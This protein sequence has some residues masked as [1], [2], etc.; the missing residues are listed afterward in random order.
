MITNLPVRDWFS[1][2]L[3]TAFFLFL[4]LLVFLVLVQVLSNMSHDL[5]VE[6]IK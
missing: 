1:P 3:V 6:M 4:V 5:D 2:R